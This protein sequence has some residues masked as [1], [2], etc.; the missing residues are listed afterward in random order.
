MLMG[1]KHLWNLFESTFVI[2]FDHSERKWFVKS[3][4][5]SYNEI[6][7]VFVNTLT[8]DDKYP[9]RNCESF[10]FP[11]QIIFSVNRIFIKF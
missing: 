9:V 8:A 7:G 10:Q 5:Y 2:F 4:P 11:I 1:A 6:L 3:L